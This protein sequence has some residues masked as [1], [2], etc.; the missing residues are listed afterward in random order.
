MNLDQA[1]DRTFEL[2]AQGRPEGPN[3]LVGCV[4]VSN[5]GQLLGQGFH[6]GAGTQHAET[7]ALDAVKQ[8]GLSPKGATLVV[9]LEPCAHQGRVGP[10]APALVQAGIR[11]VVMAMAESNPDAAGGAD[12]LRSHGVAVEL[13]PIAAQARARELNLAWWHSVSTGRPFVTLKI[14][15]SLDGRIAAPDGT[16]QWITGRQARLHGHGLRAQVGAILIGSGTLRA[17][18]PALSARDPDG[19]LARHQPLRLVMGHRPIWPEAA[20]LGPGGETIQVASHDPNDVL[21]ELAPRQI[22][23]LLIEGGATVAGAWL[24]A[25]LVDRV[26]AYLAPVVL[27]NGRPAV[28][29]P[30]VTSLS[31]AWRLATHQVTQL[32]SDVLIE[33]RRLED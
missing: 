15:A 27:G 10:C 17:D 24:S 14:A 21:Q 19:A 31:Q 6:A 29:Q 33:A 22:R 18:D 3:P 12:H 9:T 20:I 8:A 30:S 32:G 28:V 25:G 26:M 7:A 4:I 1:L 16:S 23:H 13:A 2:A 11:R 5:D